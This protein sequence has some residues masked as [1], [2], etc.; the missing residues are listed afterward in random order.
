MTSFANG[1]P[2]YLNDIAVKPVDYKG[3]ELSNLICSEFSSHH[4]Y[5][6]FIYLMQRKNQ[7]FFSVISAYRRL[8]LYSQA[9]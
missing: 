3:G 6:L 4:R 2:Q 9:I 7:D 8:L 5:G 1:G